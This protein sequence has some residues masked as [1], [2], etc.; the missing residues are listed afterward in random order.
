[1]DIMEL[2]SKVE[3]LRKSNNKIVLMLKR[4]VI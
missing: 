4:V 1:M 2:D 3:I